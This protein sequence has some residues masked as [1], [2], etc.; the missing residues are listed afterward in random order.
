MPLIKAKVFVTSTH[1]ASSDRKFGSLK[2]I[3]RPH[4]EFLL[5]SYQTVCQGLGMRLEFDTAGIA[6]K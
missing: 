6:Y 2:L 3:P 1:Y 4:P 5:V